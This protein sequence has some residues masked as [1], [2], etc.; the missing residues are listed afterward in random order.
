MASA[1]NDSR[2]FSLNCWTDC[3][4]ARHYVSFPVAV[5]MRVAQ[6]SAATIDRALKPLREQTRARRGISAT[7]TGTLLKR[8]IPIRTFADWSDARPG[9]FEMDLVAHCGWSG[10]GQFLY[11]L[12]MVDVATGWVVCAGLRD[13]RQGDRGPCAPAAPGRIALSRAWP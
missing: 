1:P 13:K 4:G 3:G 6:M 5:Q 9:F 11:T 2:R 7:R 10:A 12:S 8:Q